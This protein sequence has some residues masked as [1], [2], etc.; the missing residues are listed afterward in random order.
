MRSLIKL[1]LALVCSPLLAQSWTAPASEK[2]S[3]KVVRLTDALEKEPL[4]ANGPEARKWLIQWLT[5]TPDYSVTV[6]DILEPIPGK[7]VPNGP[8]LMVQNLFG[9]ATYQIKKPG[10]R[11]EAVL[12]QAGVESVLK[13]YQSILAHDSKAHIKYFDELLAKQQQGLLK[14]RLAPIIAKECSTNR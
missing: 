7:K 4:S 8:E 3:D 11:D 6:C 9:N 5:D 10:Q 14:E 12:Q 1:C 2:D 13:A